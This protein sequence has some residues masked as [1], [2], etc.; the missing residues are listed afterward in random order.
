MNIQINHKADKPKRIKWVDSKTRSKI[1]VD[2]KWHQLGSNKYPYLSVDIKQ[3]L[4]SGVPV[5]NWKEQKETIKKL[6]IDLFNLVNN[7]L[8]NTPC[9]SDNVEYHFSLAQKQFGKD[10]YTREDHNQKLKN[11]WDKLNSHQIFDFLSSQIGS[12]ICVSLRKHLDKYGDLYRYKDYKNSYSHWLKQI[13]SMLGTYTIYKFKRPYKRGSLSGFD[14]LKNFFDSLEDH[15]TLERKYQYST[16]PSK[17]DLWDAERLSNE[18]GLDLNDVY[19]TLSK[20]DMKPH[21][22]DLTKKIQENKLKLLQKLTDQYKIP[23][24]TNK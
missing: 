22:E 23:L 18:Y 2:V 7:H 21:L 10:I 14:L 3:V 13:E 11:M 6:N 19:V 24:V 8:I 15:R 4:N 1:L 16:L 20:S 12:S 17:C 5:Y 9:K